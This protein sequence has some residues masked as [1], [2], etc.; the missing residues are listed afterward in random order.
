MCPL[1]SQPG[2]GQLGNN[3]NKEHKCGKG[4]D[5]PKPTGG[6][7]QQSPLR[8]CLGGR[9]PTLLPDPLHQPHPSDLGVCFC[10]H[11]YKPSVSLSAPLP[12]LLLLKGRKD[13]R[14][15]IR[16]KKKNLR[17]IVSKAKKVFK[18]LG[19]WEGLVAVGDWQQPAG[20][21]GLTDVAT[22]GSCCQVG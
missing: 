8:V 20:W 1:P 7:N 4:I 2:V 3:N 22:P 17:K 16:E 11:G 13:P 12:P 21:H 5:S 19:C 9:T 10:L 14:N 15:T 18:S 6:Q